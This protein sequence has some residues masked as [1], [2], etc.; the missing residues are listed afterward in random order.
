MDARIMG[1]G[2]G[3]CSFCTHGINGGIVDSLIR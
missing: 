1:T 3:S 2:F